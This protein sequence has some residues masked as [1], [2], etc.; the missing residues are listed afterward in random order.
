[1][2]FDT[3][4]RPRVL[5]AWSGGFNLLP[6]RQ[7]NARRARRRRV[8]EWL[9]AVLA[10]CT[11]VLALAGWQ[12]VERT[13]LDAQRAAAERAFA[14]LA[15]PLAE[16]ARLS[17]EVADAHTRAARAETRA[18]PLTRLIALFEVLSDEADQ[19]IVVQQLK[20]RDH[21]T[22]LL[23]SARDHA[24]PAAWLK[25]LNAIHGV[26][27][28]EVSDLRRAG[29]SSHRTSPG[30]SAAIEFATRLHWNPLR[31]PAPHKPTVAAAHPVQPGNTRGMK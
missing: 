10:G 18:E 15:A 7:R 17:R 2:R 20:Q 22:E 12:T 5:P 6:Y 16:H 25:R 30:E 9:A 11:A 4:A 26:R 24:A 8:G 13:R 29:T 28:T 3:A 23:A 31:D 1:M 19:R 14:Q 27:D 21:E